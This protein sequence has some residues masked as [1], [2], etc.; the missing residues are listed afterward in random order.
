MGGAAVKR[1]TKDKI[2]IVAALVC[3]AAVAMGQSEG[4]GNIFN[5]TFRSDAPSGSNGFAC[6]TNGCRFDL[7]TGASDYWESDG[8]KIATPGSVA[9]SGEISTTYVHVG[10]SIRNVNAAPLTVIDAE[11]LAILGVAT[12]G[13]AACNATAPPTGTRGTIQYDTTLNRLVYCNG[14]AWKTITVDL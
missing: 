14:T 8:T 2:L 7:G 6:S 10:D 12:V 1:E 5:G 11:G 4:F 13:L 9:V 3:F